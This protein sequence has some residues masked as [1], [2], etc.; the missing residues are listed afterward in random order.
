MRAQGNIP[1]WVAVAISMGTVATVRVGWA[2]LRA[3]K[4][5]Q[6]AERRFRRQLVSGGM[7]E[8]M[9]RQLAERYI[10]TVRLR[11]LVT[12]AIRGRGPLARH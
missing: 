7:D 5:A 12:G 9:A 8:E 1:K 10:E 11:K 3:K 2:F 4:K 6:R